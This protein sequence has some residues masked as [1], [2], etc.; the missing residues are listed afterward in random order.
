MAMAGIF[1]MR[2]APGLSNVSLMQ[3]TE[4]RPSS[5]ARV[6]VDR[7]NTHGES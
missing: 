2:S 6:M 7:Q 3:W 1:L 5:L 4:L